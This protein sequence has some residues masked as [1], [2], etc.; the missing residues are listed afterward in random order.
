MDYL[1][2]QVKKKTAQNIGTEFQNQECAEHSGGNGQNNG[3]NAAGTHKGNKQKGHKKHT[4]C[5]EI[6]HKKQTQKTDAR[7]HQ[8]SRQVLLRLQ[9]I[10]R[11][12]A[13]KNKGNLDEFRRLHGNRTD[14]DP[15]SRSVYRGCKD[16]IHGKEKNGRAANPT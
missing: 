3:P 5:A 9:A 12:R 13:D 8:K 1:L 6:L 4:G 11:R 16:K 2:K 7:E 15:V 14:S 10:Q